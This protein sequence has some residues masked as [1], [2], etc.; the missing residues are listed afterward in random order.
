[1]NT[2]VKKDKTSRLINRR[3]KCQER[4]KRKQERKKEEWAPGGL[5]TVRRTA[6]GR[7]GYATRGRRRRRRR[8]C[9]FCLPSLLSR[10]LSSSFSK[11]TQSRIYR[12]PEEIRENNI[13][14][15]KRKWEKG[16]EKERNKREEE[17]IEASRQ[18]RKGAGSQAKRCLL[19]EEKRKEEEREGERNNWKK[20]FAGWDRL[21]PWRRQNRNEERRRD[22][23]RE[24]EE[25]WKEENEE[26][27]EERAKL[28]KTLR[29]DGLHALETLSWTWTTD[30]I[31]AGDA[32]LWEGKQAE[33]RRRKE[34]E[35]ESK[36]TERES[37]F[38]RCM[39]YL[40]LPGD[41]DDSK[42]E[43]LFSGVSVGTPPGHKNRRTRET[44]VCPVQINHSMCWLYLSASSTHIQIYK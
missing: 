43:E 34:E 42:T 28:W 18:T 21:G 12:F 31:A 14:T 30:R 27:E 20:S 11:Q 10:F 26:V 36:K 13:H 25:R 37:S 1:M 16:R 17:M 6:R 32:T 23:T 24:S 19:G 39:F 44:S 22:E 4:K 5:L 9:C 29:R 7:D 15:W 38:S 3:E 41:S 2:P 35:E 40:R 33:K 8:G